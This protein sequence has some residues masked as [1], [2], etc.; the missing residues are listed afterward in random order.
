MY[1]LNLPLAPNSY[2]IWYIDFLFV[3][4]WGSSYL[5]KH[6]HTLCS[7]EIINSDTLFQ[8]RVRALYVNDKVWNAI[9]YNR[10]LKMP[11]V[12]GRGLRPM[13]VL[14]SPPCC[15]TAAVPLPPIYR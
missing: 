2:L 9:T 11:Q 13:M 12:L 14:Q 7:V 3:N 1:P 5:R 4:S 15:I 6:L 10:P 8:A